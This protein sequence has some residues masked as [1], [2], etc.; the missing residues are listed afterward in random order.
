MNQNISLNIYVMSY[1]RA[2]L[3]TSYKNFH[4]CT[5]VVREEDAES[6][7]E[8]GIEDMLV[9]PNDA[10]LRNGDPIN[11]F[12]STF[13][14]ILENTPEEVVCICDDD[15]LSY[16]YRSAKNTNVNI[17]YEDFKD[18]IEDELVRLAQILVDLRL[19]FLAT[20]PLLTPYSFVREFD[21]VG[22]P[23]STRIVNKA[24]FKAK[25]SNRDEA[26]S[27]VDMVM[28]ELI[29]NRIILRSS[30]FLTQTLP[31]LKTSGGT[32]NNKQIQDTLHLA[33]KNKWGM[34]YQYDEKKSISRIKVKR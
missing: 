1:H 28:Q 3:T 29:A 7:R 30:Y 14:W 24:E 32:A 22:S 20:N 2:T 23:G 26:N 11:G 16:H 21:T 6:Y 4:K 10:K 15:I 13:Y 18:R 19:G 31:N 34:Y 25:Y 17:T 12:M 8:V 33:M 5:Y 27:D 9:I